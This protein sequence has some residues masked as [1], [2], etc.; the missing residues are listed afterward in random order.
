VVSKVSIKTELIPLQEARISNEI[1]QRTWFQPSDP[2]GYRNC[3]FCYLPRHDEAD[4]S[5]LWRFIWTIDI[6]DGLS[7]RIA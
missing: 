4:F 1:S 6:L 7:N 3:S 5:N 2:T